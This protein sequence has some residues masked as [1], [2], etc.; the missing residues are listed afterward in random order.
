MSSSK[1]EMEPETAQ[2][3]KAVQQ[4]QIQALLANVEELICQNEELQKTMESQNAE[5]QRTVENQNE[6]ELNSQANRR[7]RTSGE[8][9]S[10]MENELHN[11]RRWTN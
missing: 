1:Y 9:S 7:D 6:G 3:P 2:Q 5:R 10:R 11:M 4:Q 8:D